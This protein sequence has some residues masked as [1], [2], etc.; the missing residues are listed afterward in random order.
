M[1]TILCY[2][3]SNTWGYTPATG[4]RYSRQI[5]WPG[6]A[7]AALGPE[8]ELLNEG[9]NARTTV[10]DDP[11]KEGKNGLAYL[12]VCMTTHK[13]LDLVILALGTNDL[14][15]TD[16]AGAALGAE[17]LVRLVRLI[18]HKEDSSPVFHA[19]PEIL[20]ISP[21][22]LG[23]NAT[24]CAPAMRDGYRQSLLF[25]QAYEAVA[26]TWHTHF[27]DAAQYA[28]PSEKDCVHMEPEDH[29][30]LG[31]AAAAKIQAIFA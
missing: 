9:L 29:R 10:Y 6:V 11:W 13:P 26:R 21:I 31:L 4:V 24:Q 14:K 30:A 17:A 27:L 28:K 18:S 5:T 19:G 22:H 2:G 1:K 8:Y 16:A 7:Q 12:D 23:K 3:D 20:L 25:A 15:L